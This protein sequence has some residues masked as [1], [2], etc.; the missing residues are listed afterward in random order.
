MNERPSLG[1]LLRDW[2]KRRGLSQMAL[3]LEAGI[4]QRHMSFLETGRAQPSRELVLRLGEEMSLSLRDRNSM[5][6]S[7]GFAPLYQHRSFEEPGMA[8][9]SAAV[10]RVLAGQHP[11][12]ALAIDRHWNMLAA[13]GAVGVLLEGL[14]DAL[15]APPVNVLRISLHPHGLA[16]RILNFGEWRAHVL[17]RLKHQVSVS[18]DAELDRLHDEIRAYPIPPGS[19]RA[20][21]D[22]SAN[23]IVVPLRMSS[24]AGPLS[25]IS[26]TTVFG[27]AVDVALSEIAIETF[28]PADEETTGAMRALQR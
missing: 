21:H 17:A 18:A 16:P 7:A 12:P 22:V 24:S 20:S 25:F 4:S 11:H 5:L 14:S 6:L 9:A 26:T 10:Q 27:T 3:S 8:A 2:R 1:T 15:M 23:E 19:K 13:N 28:F